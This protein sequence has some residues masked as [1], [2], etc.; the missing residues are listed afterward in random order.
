MAKPNRS[1]RTSGGKLKRLCVCALSLSL[2][3]VMMVLDFSEQVFLPTTAM[4]CGICVKLVI[5][6][7]RTEKKPTNTGSLAP[8]VRFVSFVYV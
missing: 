8:N 3:F 2:S 1:D 6:Q 7:R 5:N 4:P